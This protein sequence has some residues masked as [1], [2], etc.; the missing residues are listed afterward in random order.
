M[1]NGI[2]T[3][4]RNYGNNLPAIDE[5]ASLRQSSPTRVAQ[6]L[7]QMQSKQVGYD[8]AS[9][10]KNAAVRRSVGGQGGHVDAGGRDQRSE[11]Q[12]QRRNSNGSSNGGY[13]QQQ[14]VQQQQHPQSVPKNWSCG[15]LLGQ[16]CLTSTLRT[17]LLGCQAQLSTRLPLSC[18]SLDHPVAS[19]KSL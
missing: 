9:P 5:H 11:S 3:R 10:M 4:A 16:V 15:D 13:Q 12:V 17:W 6:H 8:P 14:L 19:L 7:G 18:R 1:N 2:N